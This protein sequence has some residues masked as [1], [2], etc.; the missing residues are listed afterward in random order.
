M[1]S[2]V[3]PSML[4]DKVCSKIRNYQNFLLMIHED[5]DG[6]T[7]AATVAI[8]LVLRSLEKNVSMV[9]KDPV[10]APFLFLPESAKIKKDILFG[11]FEV[12]IIIDCGDLKRTGFS[13]RLK[14]FSRVR[15]NLINI[16]HH[17]KNDLWKIAN[18]NLVDQKVSSASEIVWKLIKELNVPITKEIS[19]AILTGI[20]TDTG[21]FKHP[22]TTPNTLRVYSEL[23]NYGARLK[24]ITKN[25]SLN[26]SVAS[27]RLWGVVLSRIH[28]NQ[29]LGIV[30][31]V[32]TRRDLSQCNTNYYDLSGVVNL[33]NAIPDSQAAILFFETPEGLIRASLRTEKDNVD[34][35]KI[36]KLFGGGGHKKAA[37]FSIAADLWLNNR[38]WE[39]V[40]K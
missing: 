36:A 20:Y 2:G 27:L 32:V 35:S 33:M 39:I 29:E 13:E 15:K 40:L 12:I 19:T 11:D 24:Q 38:S 6:D 21:G 31:S 26:K 18:I 1:A 16:D 5:P 17:P 22:N 3:D 7:L 34:V 14:K 4:L 25:V 37:G 9:C 8:Y 30:S 10:P 28:K 23:L